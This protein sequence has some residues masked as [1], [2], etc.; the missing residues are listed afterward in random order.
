MVARQRTTNASFEGAFGHWFVLVALLAMLAVNLLASWL[1]L[2]GQTTAELAARF[3]ERFRP[4]DYTFAIWLPIYA[5]LLAYAVF[6]ALP[7][8]R[9]NPRLAA[10]RSPFML[11]CGANMA[12]IFCWH[13]QLI[14]ASMLAMLALLVALISINQRLHW[15]NGEQPLAELWCVEAPFRMYLAWISVASLANLSAWVEA[16]A[17]LPVG[18]SG[19]SFAVG[20][21]LF[22]TLISA[23]VGWLRHDALYLAVVAWAFIGIVVRNGASSAVSGVA[24][25][26][27]LIMGA[28]IL[29]ALAWNRRHGAEPPFHS[30][31]TAI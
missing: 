27:V 17:L 18:M 26:G 23:L 29:S 16:Q 3:S 24:M 15:G 2:N 25:G 10:I 11:S 28:L 9:D 14:G 7:S 13:Y 20:L 6:Q 8:Q 4:A 19:S 30:A 5:G 1:P 31:G 22:A 12:W 21:V